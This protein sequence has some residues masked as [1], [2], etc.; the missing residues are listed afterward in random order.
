MLGTK[1]FANFYLDGT[2]GYIARKQ[3]L[4]ILPINIE[5]GS[6]YATNPDN[7]MGYYYLSSVK[8]IG[9]MPRFIG[10]ISQKGIT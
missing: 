1:L 9:T 5:N 3:D 2:K 6:S 8:S 4:S 10:P 7:S